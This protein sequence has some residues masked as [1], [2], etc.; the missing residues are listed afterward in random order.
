VQDG[1]CGRII[2]VNGEDS[3]IENS[4]IFMSLK[5]RDEHARVFVSVFE[6]E[7]NGQINAVTDHSDGIDL[8]PGRCHTIGSLE[9]RL[10]GLEVKWPHNISKIQAVPDTLVLV[11]SSAPVNLQYLATPELALQRATSNQ[12]SL[13]N[14]FFRLAQGVGRL[15]EAEKRTA[16]IRYDIIHLPFLLEPLSLQTTQ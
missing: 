4:K 16:P 7:V 11:I 5:N 2:D 1:R 12:T 14:R 8:P 6:V 13:D 10:E 9:G 3:I 15:I